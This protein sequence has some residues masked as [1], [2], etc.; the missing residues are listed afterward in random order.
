MTDVAV[1]TAT[2]LR[3]DIARVIDNWQFGVPL[4]YTALDALFVRLF[5]FQVGGIAPYAAFCR[6]R[7][8]EPAAVT[9]WDQIPCAPAD[10]WKLLPMATPSAV[11][12]PVALFE[13]SGTTTGAPGRS[14][15]ADTDLYHQAA[16]ATFGQYVADPAACVG[17]TWLN[18]VVNPAQRPHSSLGHMVGDLCRNARAV[19]WLL[20][21]DLRP[22][23]MRFA[24]LCT[25]AATE[26]QPVLVTATSVAL[27]AVLRALPAGWS[28]QLPPGSRLMDTG[29]PKGRDLELDRAAQHAELR[30]RLGLPAH[31][32]VGEFGMT[33]LASQRYEPVWRNQDS[34]Q[35]AFAG[36]PWLRT[37]I[38]RVAVGAAPVVACGP[39]EVGLVAHLDLANVDTCA[40]IQTGDLGSLDA[41][42]NLTLNGRL[43]G[44]QLR[45]CG[46]DVMGGSLEVA[47]S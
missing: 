11:A 14:Y 8:V 33:E 22:D 3:V 29:G 47:Q 10:L 4:D 16:R 9:R 26:A 34:T 44:A 36:P 24:H 6:S 2:T 7:N 15:L 40:F 42:G 39:G 18:L 23:A 1:D 32:I 37:R 17:L 12:D 35:R 27:H 41:E 31:A 46:L 38:F 13:T 30:A 19:H 21:D 25:E 28:V 5:Q 43:A 45:G 20:D